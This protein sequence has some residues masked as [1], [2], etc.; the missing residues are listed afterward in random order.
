MFASLIKF[1]K[2]FNPHNMKKWLS[3]FSIINQFMMVFQGFAVLIILQVVLGISLMM[4]MNMTIG[5]GTI[6]PNQVNRVFTEIKVNLVELQIIANEKYSR[7]G[8]RSHQELL[9]E[10]TKKLQTFKGLLAGENLQ[11]IEKRILRLSEAL[12]GT[13]TY[14]KYQIIRGE[15]SEITGLLSK[16][17]QL[18]RRIRA[19][20]IR[21]N[22]FIVLIILSMIVAAAGLVYWIIVAILLAYEHQYANHYFE[23]IAMKYRQNRLEKE[24]M[25]IPGTDY[26]TL[27]TV[28]QKYFNQVRERY[29]NLY[30][31]CKD[32]KA[33]IHDLEATI[34]RND[35]HCINVKE[36]LRKIINDSYHSLDFFPDLAEHIKNLNISL[37]ESQ[38]E[39]AAIHQ[40]IEN[41]AKFFQKSPLQVE[42]INREID[43]RDEHTQEITAALKELRKII[44]NIQ[45]ILTIFDSIAQQTTVLSLNASIEAARAG[46]AGSGFDIAA[47]EIDVLADRI[48]VIPPELLKIVNRVQK[49]MLDAIRTNEA[50]VPQHRQGKRY[51]ESISTE[52]N[53]FWKE[54]ELIIKDL[55]EFSNLAYQFEIR[56]KSLE[57]FT[58]LIAD[59]NRQIPVN[60][61][62]VNA[63]LDVVDKS[64]QLPVS[65]DNIT[66]LLN[67]LNQK[68]H[69]IISE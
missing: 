69:E 3:K 55:Q 5:R 4:T 62:K 34:A 54:L 42:E 39:S 33:T 48:G 10:L 61:G 46:A 7:I 14:D 63:T 30:N 58:T 45:Q 12:E 25:D 68:L 6:R 24:I 26:Q 59:L 56:E 27:K 60:Y 51:F 20:E 52:L 2:L 29:E 17:Q 44:D 16:Q 8:N 64:K 22:L 1:F 23:K 9:K 18:N 41:A 37:N 35:E 57:E 36:T 65:L 15:V 19:K 40:S 13:I 49:R 43:V 38:Q 50:I 11:S 32:M 31:H 66:E 28:M 53:L 47:A 21:Y 67:G